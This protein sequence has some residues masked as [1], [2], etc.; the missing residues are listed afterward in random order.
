MH[1]QYCATT[2]S[3]SRTFYPFQ[4]K[5][6]THY[7]LPSPWPPGP[8]AN[9]G[10]SDSVLPLLCLPTPIKSDL[11]EAAS[12]PCLL[13]TAPCGGDLTG[14]SGVILSP[15][16]PEPYP[17]GKECD[18]KVT[19]SPDYVIALV[20][21]MYVPFPGRETKGSEQLVG[22]ELGAWVSIHR[23]TASAWPRAGVGAPKGG[24]PSIYRKSPLGPERHWVASHIFFLLIIIFFFFSS[25]AVEIQKVGPFWILVFFP[26]AFSPLLL[27]SSFQLAPQLRNRLRFSSDA[28]L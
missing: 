11:V 2:A 28:P 14:P 23:S 21:N 15:N 5:P 6:Q 9:S 8:G 16:Y 18:W 10:V 26:L 17:P 12:Y 25:K 1:P 19:V 20:F 3:S 4:G 13:S 24:K 7:I 27:P 22:S